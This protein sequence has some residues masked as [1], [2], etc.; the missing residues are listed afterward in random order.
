MIKKTLSE[1]VI[2]FDYCIG[3]GGCAYISP[4]SFHIDFDNFGMLKAFNIEN[5]D[6][7]TIAEICPFSNEADNEDELIKDQ[8]TKQC[9]YNDSIG[10]YI[11]C[12]AGYVVE[13]KYRMYGS[14]GGVGKW[15]LNKLLE[16]NHVDKVFQVAAAKDDIVLFDY[17]LYQKGE[18]LLEGSRSAYYP[19]SLFST[20][21]YIKNHEGT[22][23]ITALPCF[24]KAIRLLTKKDQI[25]H[26][27][28]KYVIGI[29]CG[30]L[31]STA[32]AENFSWQLGVRPED[33]SSIEF[34]EKL[35]NR[36]AN[37]KGVFVVDKYNLRTPIISSKTLIGGD[38]GHGFFK[39][40][41]CDYCDDIVGETADVSIG[42]AW[43]QEYIHDH[44]G[45][46]IV[47][48]RNSEINDLIQSCIKSGKL[49]LKRISVETVIESQ[50]AGI[51][52]RREGLA[53]RLYLRRKDNW[54]PKKRVNPKR[55]SNRN[56]RKVYFLREKIRD[57]SHSLFFEAK[58]ELNY[59]IFYMG[60][61]HYLNKY[62]ILY[63]V[64]WK[65]LLLMFLTRIPVTT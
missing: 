58:S 34:R 49:N 59:D 20:L 38:W 14:S 53:Y 7:E 4:E 42:D 54:I 32:F 5:N 57:V 39:Y 43:L 47:I 25:L 44:H 37:E 9:K 15:L 27:R 19:I 63:S 24:A 64:Y 52:H 36:K 12:Y 10:N 35:K 46:N 51:R 60:I 6:N 13:N 65:R 30:H 22:Y 21:E 62:H 31:K 55:I 23:A 40:K 56:R 48:T 29:V 28:I 33:L 26:K 1:T 8:F 11:E 16:L 3:C 61:K 50:S 17:K 45:N 2:K 41:A 18:N